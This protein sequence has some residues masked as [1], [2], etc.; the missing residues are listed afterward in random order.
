VAIVG[1]PPR[2][3]GLAWD[4]PA[5]AVGAVYALPA[6]AVV[7]VDRASGVA[8]AVGVL[9]A[10][11]VGVA[12]TRRARLLVVLAGLLT[13]VPMLLGGLLAGVPVLAVAT[14]ALLGVASAVLAAASGSWPRWP[15]PPRPTAAGGT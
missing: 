15:A 5:A 6:L 10:A 1:S 8:V 9:P 14:I 12:P 13:G 3:P 2:S 4:W 7:L 11:L